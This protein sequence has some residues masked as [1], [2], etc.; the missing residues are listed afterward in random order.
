MRTNLL[1]YIVFSITFVLFCASCGDEQP[2]IIP[3]TPV[4]IYGELALPEFAPLRFEGNAIV[5]KGFG[6]QNNGVIVYRINSMV[7]AFDCT[8]PNCMM[9][10][11]QANAV[12]LDGLSTGTATCP[13]CGVQY[14]LLNG[15]AEG[16]KYP[17]QSYTA[18]I[19]NDV[20][21]VHN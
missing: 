1:Y 12:Q 9:E 20:L 17:L 14:A 7:N 18:S 5:V 3:N 8:C 13:V 11:S 21:H 16:V 4:N 19:S 6:Y 15:W 10:R 2:R